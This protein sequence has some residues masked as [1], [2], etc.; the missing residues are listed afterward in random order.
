MATLTSGDTLSL[1]NLGSATG[2]GASNISLGTIKGTPISGD[3]IGLSE[4]AIDS[5]DSASGFT[6]V[7]EN[8]TETFTA[9]FTGAGTYHGL[10]IGT[11]PGNFTWSVPAGSFISLNTNNGAIAT[12]DVSDMNPQSPVSQSVLQSAQ[13]HTLRLVYNDG[14]N[15][16]I[17][18]ENGYNTNIDRTIYSVDDYDGN[19]AVLCLPVD[20]P[21]TLADGTNIEIGEVE[22]GMKLKSF[23]LS[24]LGQQEGDYLKWSTDNLNEEEK[25]VTVKNV[26]FSFSQNLVGFNNN[27][28]ISTKT[29]PF[30]VKDSVDDLYRFKKA[31]IITTGDKLIKFDGNSLIE[32]LVT[33]VSQNTDVTEIVTLDVEEEDTY[34]ANGYI[35]HN[36]GG[37][38]HTDL[39]A[40]GT[41]TSLTYTVVNGETKNLTWAAG[42]SSGDTGV[43][44]Y[45]VQVATDAGFTNLLLDFTEYSSTTL[46]IVAQPTGTLYARVRAIDHGL[47][48]SYTDISFS[49]TQ[50]VGI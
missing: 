26:V 28:I 25:E 11:T 44:A 33:N 45:D 7:V 20:T 12:F 29:H 23:A 36:K 48:S 42:T 31:S 32:I 43:T 47:K 40:P 14:Y 24:G 35:T 8:T 21:I 49:H 19:A 39:G 3:D 16:H 5:V 17:G 1:N 18:S 9:Q 50:G 6:Y 13:T 38:T 15:D 4:F 10:T 34:L 30:L 2:Q 41:P 27:E 22:E 37:N 46:N